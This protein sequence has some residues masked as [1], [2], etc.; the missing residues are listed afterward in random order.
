MKTRSTWLAG[1]LAFAVGGT[2]WAVCS[3]IVGGEGWDG[4]IYYTTLPLVAV[5]CGALGAFAP[6]RPWRLGAAA[7]SAQA[8]GLVLTAGGGASMLP[9]GLALL[10]ILGGGLA[11]CAW[12]GAWLGRRVGV[13][14]G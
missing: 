11:L 12:V 14:R 6:K 13:G 9:V 4:G 3:A 5:A 1:T 10:A 7:A 2:H 8:V